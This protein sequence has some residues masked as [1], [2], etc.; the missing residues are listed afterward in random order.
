MDSNNTYDDLLEIPIN[1]D[2]DNCQYVGVMDVGNQFD[3]LNDIHQKYYILTTLNSVSG[4]VG[5]PI[6]FRNA[7]EY[8]MA[9]SI[10]NI[11][12]ANNTVTVFGAVSEIN[13]VYYLNANMAVVASVDLIKTNCCPNLDNGRVLLRQP[14]DSIT[15]LDVGCIGGGGTEGGMAL[16]QQICQ[17]PLGGDIKCTTQLD[18]GKPFLNN[19]PANFVFPW[20]V[21]TFILFGMDVSAAYDAVLI[22][23]FQEWV[24]SLVNV[25]GWVSAGANSSQYFNYRYFDNMDTSDQ[26]I[27]GESREN[28]SYSLLD[29]QGNLFYTE[30]LPVSC[31]DGIGDAEGE[32]ELI[33]K[34]PG[35][36]DVVRA[37]VNTIFNQLPTKQGQ[38]FQCTN[39][40]ATRCIMNDLNNNN[41]DTPW[42]FCAITL[43]GQRQN[44]I[45]NNF[46]TRAQMEAVLIQMGW[47]KQG[48]GDSGVFTL[49][50]VLNEPN[51]QSFVEICGQNGE[52]LIADLMVNCVASCADDESGSGGMDLVLTKN[53]IG[54]Y[55]W[56]APG[57]INGGPGL[58]NSLVIN[59]G[60]TGI[61]GDVPDCDVEPLYDLRIRLKQSLVDVINTHFSSNGPYW[62]L[63]YKLADGEV[64][65]IRKTIGDINEDFS[66]RSLVECLTLIGWFSSVDLQDIDSNTDEVTVTL[67]ASPQLIHGIC[68]N[69]VGELGDDLPFSYV[70]PT[71][72]VANVTCI[73]LEDE[74]TKVLIKGQTGFCFV[75]LSCIVPVIPPEK[76][77]DKELCNLPSCGDEVDGDGV[78][79]FLYNVCINFNICDIEKM[80][81]AFG[82]D[83][84]IELR[85]YILNASVGGGTIP[86]NQNLG[87][88]TGTSEQFLQRIIAAML[89]LGW[90]SPNV[91]ERPVEINMETTQNISYIS[92]AIV[93]NN[94][95]TPPYPCLYPAN[96]SQTINCPSIDPDNM[97]MIKTPEGRVCWT[98]IC[99]V[100]GPA[101]RRG[102]TGA[103]G[104][105]GIQGEQ[106]FQGPVG[107]TGI[108]ERGPPGEQ[109]PIGPAGDTYSLTVDTGNSED[110]PSTSGPVEITNA[111]TLRVWSS[112]TIGRQVSGNSL[113]LDANN[114]LFNPNGMTPVE[115]GI[116]P[117]D[118]SRP[119]FFYNGSGLFIWNPNSLSWDTLI[120]G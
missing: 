58:G 89:N 107:P 66:L 2:E 44:P 60:G 91:N 3:F 46:N 39:I 65:L 64:I 82:T 72:E 27:N 19:N 104:N 116:T 67:L 75:D 105:Q 109:G 17:L 73:G 49:S 57:C 14:D 80:R 38:T 100:A 87:F 9:L 11:V 103:Q 99:P 26:G 8:S 20:R 23:S 93:A 52:K 59:C 83:R 48:G 10:L 86:I 111:E 74:G 71:T 117:D 78:S 53:E 88:I 79:D 13:K 33:Y 37:G 16:H 92:F 56:T 40:I 4:V 47:N 70:I 61:L 101:G 21:N 98:P 1:Q 76:D 43:N 110:G 45:G 31:D 15:W 36:G 30:L 84:R 50:T 69:R 28:S 12:I 29:A 41:I 54:D 90:N 119:S 120:T 24:D 108:G 32:V 94:D 77:L 42:Y 6:A 55:Y 35:S 113:K 115:N 81:D 114:I 97:T 7:N 112:G 34:F 18:A 102:E 68:I 96:C 25:G 118:T 5:G 85:A 62:I 51:N 22:N 106:G 95:N 63:S